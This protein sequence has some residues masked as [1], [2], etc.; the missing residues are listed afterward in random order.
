MFRGGINKLGREREGKR[1]D[2]GSRRTN[3]GLISI[4][5]LN[6]SMFVEQATREERRAV[7]K[8][9]DLVQILWHLGAGEIAVL[10]L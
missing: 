4:F 6:A 10:N 9:T 7:R 8:A 1:D 3:R 5:H 2:Q